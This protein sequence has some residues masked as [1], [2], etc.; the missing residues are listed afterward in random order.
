MKSCRL[1]SRDMVTDGAK[2]DTCIVWKGDWVSPGPYAINDCVQYLGSSYICIVPA[3]TELP[4]DTGHFTLLAGLGLTGPTGPQGPTGPSGADGATG[5]QGPTT[6]SA[7]IVV[8]ERSTQVLIG[9][10]KADIIIPAALNGMN[11]VRAQAEVITAGTTN[12]T[13]VAIYN[14]TDSQEMLSA[15][16]SIASGAT[17]GTPGTINT[18][19]DDVVTND[20]LRI[21]VDA[22]STTA[23]LGLLVILEFR[24]P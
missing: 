5:P 20:R 15:N 6:P 17:V 22:V 16:I 7:C 1:N 12:A 18:S 24:L 3:T 21:D 9:D 14:A 10:G 2:L 11:L 23:P 13:T 8:F 19:Y 4:T